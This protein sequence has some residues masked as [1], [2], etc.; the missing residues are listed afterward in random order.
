MSAMAVNP[1]H[2]PKEGCIY[3]TPLKFTLEI[4]LLSNFLFRIGDQIGRKGGLLH[5]QK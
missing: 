5:F 1:E 4:Q 2:A 3:N